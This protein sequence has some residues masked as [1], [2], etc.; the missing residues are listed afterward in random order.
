MNWLEKLRP[1]KLYRY[2]FYR[3]HLMFVKLRNDPPE[4]SACLLMSLTVFFQLHFLILGIAALINYDIWG[5]VYDNA[6]FIQKASYVL[7][8]GILCY[9]IFYHKYKWRK[10]MEEFK[11]KADSRYAKFHLLI[12][13]LV[14]FGCLYI[15]GYF[16]FL[17][18]PHSP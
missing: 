4:F 2:M 14:S 9:F 12:Y 16:A 6:N 18:G 1:P 13:L 5:K 15:S 17:T 10:F 3:M 7:V 8:F 11:G